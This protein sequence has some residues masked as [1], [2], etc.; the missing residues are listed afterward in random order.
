M[1]SSYPVIAIDGPSAAGKGS[2]A[3]G[4][5][6]HYDFAWLDS[7]LLYR[8]VAKKHRDN[9]G[10]L[11]DDKA[12]TQT[13]HTLC[14]ADLLPDSLRDETIGQWA[15]V[16]AAYRGVRDALLDFQRSYGSC[17]P[18]GKKGSV[19]DGRDIG[20]VVFPDTPYKIFLQ[21]SFEIRVARRTKELHQRGFQVIPSQVRETMCLRDQRDSQRSLAPLRLCDDALLLDS[22]ERTAD[23]V[24]FEACG[25]LEA[26]GLPAASCPA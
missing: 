9:G 13:A 8:A 18:H 24:M 4:L 12:V 6:K 25:W 3:R 15:S 23:E 7:G 22:D 21:A 1:K 16:I 26:K 19:I 14:H 17:P 11:D 10:S 5:A 2:L 20:S